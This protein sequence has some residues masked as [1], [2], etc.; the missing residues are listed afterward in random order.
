MVIEKQEQEVGQKND[1]GEEKDG[2]VDVEEGGG[3]AANV[4]R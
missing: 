2:N 1:E 3:R 4:S